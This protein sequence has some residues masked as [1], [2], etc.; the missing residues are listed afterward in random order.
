M[1]LKVS[2][3]IRHV[4]QKNKLFVTISIFSNKRLRFQPTACNSSHD[5]LMMSIDTNNIAILNISSV[6]YRFIGFR[7]SKNE[8]INLFKNAD[9]SRKS[10]SL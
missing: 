10:G 7:I 3:L 5:L 8:A 6:Y 1:F 9:V 2:M 4:H